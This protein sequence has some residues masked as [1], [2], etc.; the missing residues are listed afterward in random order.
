MSAVEKDA[1]GEVRREALVSLGRCHQ[2]PMSFLAKV[3]QSHDQ[4]VEVRELAALQV[5]KLGGSE[6]PKLLADAV[7]DV[8]ADPTADERSVSLATACLRALGQLHDGSKPVLEALGAASNEPVSGEVRAAAMEAIGQVCPDGAGEVL[9]RG[10]KDA[11][12]IVRR[13]AQQAL[14]KC[15]R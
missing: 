2:A 7:T 11:E 13:A 12:P 5:A 15:H 6:A 3:L 8:L 1:A 4:P 9:R 10:Q 14:D